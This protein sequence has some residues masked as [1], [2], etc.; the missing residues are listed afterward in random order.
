MLI[1]IIYIRTNNQKYP[2][3]KSCMIA[4]SLFA[5]F[6]IF[7]TFGVNLNVKIS[8]IRLGTLI[9]RTMVRVSSLF[10]RNISRLYK[11]VYINKETEAF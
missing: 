9:H 10:Y 7:Y 6:A 2:S 11:L 3:S 4:N 1:T 5:S 8:S